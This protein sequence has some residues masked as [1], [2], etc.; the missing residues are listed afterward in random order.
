MVDQKNGNGKIKPRH[1]LAIVILVTIMVFFIDRIVFTI[2]TVFAVFN[3]ILYLFYSQGGGRYQVNS[4]GVV[5]RFICG[6]ILLICIP[7][8]IVAFWTSGP[9]VIS[10]LSLAFVFQF[11]FVNNFL[12]QISKKTHPQLEPCPVCDSRKFVWSE[13]GMAVC[14]FCQWSSNRDE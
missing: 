10:T 1:F 5:M 11:M 13:S 8:G 12:K 6:I 3:V 4:A 7:V 9:P 14:V 2:S